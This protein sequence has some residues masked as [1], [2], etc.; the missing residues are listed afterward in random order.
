M[1]I[2]IVVPSYNRERRCDTR[3]EK[4]PLRRVA[5]AVDQDH[6]GSVIAHGHV[7]TFVTSA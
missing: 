4:H 7:V 2:S 3:G 6:P 1:W 5:E